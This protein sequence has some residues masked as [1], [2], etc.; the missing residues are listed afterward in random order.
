MNYEVRVGFD[1]RT[2]DVV[3]SK[4]YFYVLDKYDAL[5]IGHEKTRTS[6]MFISS[7]KPI[8]LEGL[9]G[10]LGDIPVL[11]VKKVA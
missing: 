5:G 3:A 9:A 2:A 1:D 7:E 11:S 10:E 8:T 6:T 4:A